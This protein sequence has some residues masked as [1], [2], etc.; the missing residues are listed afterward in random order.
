LLFFRVF[1]KFKFL[2]F[3]KISRKKTMVRMLHK[4]VA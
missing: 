4:V 1:I 3:A 2:S